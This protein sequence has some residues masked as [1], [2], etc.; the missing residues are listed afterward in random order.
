M[1]TAI[2][3]FLSVLGVLYVTVVYG[4][5]GQPVKFEKC[6]I[7]DFTQNAEGVP[8]GIR[9]SIDAP[10]GATPQAKVLTSTIR[11][12]MIKSDIGKEVGAPKNIA[13]KLAVKDYATRLKAKMRRS[14]DGP[15][16]CD[17][18]VN[19]SYQNAA[20]VVLHLANG[21]YGNG[22]PQ[23]FDIVV[24]L[25]DGRVIETDKMINISETAL[26]QLIK[27]NMESGDE[28]PII[29]GDGYFISPADSGKC[30]ILWPTG[31]HF[32]G[33]VLVPV[34]EV[35]KYLTFEGKAMFCL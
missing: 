5:G 22:G 25:K 3:L 7:E 23:E 34:S 33:E 26:E 24:R 4:A 13:M 1:K 2:R 32:N 16:Q 18:M 19:C 9:I 14:H 6:I 27:K 17:L 30:K 8:V 31:S 20:C 29:L 10:V 28:T 11:S 21:M 35:E 15:M 12:I